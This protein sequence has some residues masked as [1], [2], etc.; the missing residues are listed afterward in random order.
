MTQKRR[1]RNF[2]ALTF[3]GL[4]IQTG[5]SH[6]ANPVQERR[7]LIGTTAADQRLTDYFRDHASRLANR[8]L[9]NIK[10][11]KT[12]ETKR[13]QYR[14]Q[15]FEMLGLSP[16]P[17]KTDLKP[18][19]TN[20]ITSD[21]FIVENITFQSRPGLYVTGNL[22]RPIKQEGRIP[23]ILYVCGHG[24]VKKNGVIYGNKVHYQHHGEWFARNGYICLTIDTLQLGEIEGI[25]HGTYREGMWWW[26]SRGYTPAG[27]EAW[28]CIRALDYLQ[29]R[30]EVD[31][32]KLGVTGRSGGGAYS[33]W[34][35]ALDE[36]IK[37]AVPVAGI[38][39]LK[40]HVIDGA[41]EGH[42]DCMFM[43]NTYQWD[44]AQVAALVAPRP[45][46]ISNTDKDSIFP[47]DGV[48]DVYNS[49]MKIYELYG[50][51]ENLGLQITEGPHKDTQE[52]R[53]HSFRWFNH[54][55][56]G[57]DSLI[58]MAATKFHTP[59]ELKVFKTLPEDQKNAK[60]QETFVKQGKAKV[61][62]DSA[63]WHQMREQWKGQLLKKSFRA[64]PKKKDSSTQTKVET[65]IK[66]GLTLKT[67]SFDSQKHVPLKLFVVI[68]ENTK[69]PRQVELAVLNQTEWDT[70]LK[71]L[72]PVFSGR[73]SATPLSPR[74]EK[75]FQKLRKNVLDNQSAVAYFTPR[76][77]GLDVWNSEE[78]KQIQIR[79]RFYLLGQSLEGMQIWD[80]RR[81]IQ[82]LQAQPEFAKADL[83][84]V[85]TGQAAAL[86]LYAS[87]FEKG[88]SELD[89]TGMPASH[90]HGPALL[91][92]LRFMDLPQA[93]AMAA[94]RSR[95]KLNDVK[96]EDWKYSA[97]VGQKMGWG[98]KQ[99]Q[100]SK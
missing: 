75:L 7:K 21:G 61:P 76:G 5:G 14:K 87:L 46:L 33:W 4:L 48:V 92:V 34:I 63:Q 30:P 97:E 58:E 12:W 39:N 41:V 88:I 54:F 15:L 51:P 25:H 42:C 47:L 69:M 22:Y 49:T 59:E 81:A 44:Y 67:I 64:W 60:I 86:C 45:L 78:R 65:S 85:G 98:E 23:A 32:E 57:D 6:A 79:R 40:N 38:T 68:P 43:V 9:K 10:D 28:N 99:L 72:T 50:V 20:S 3:I 96:L 52:L 27:V 1:H 70:Y 35:A 13:V 36:R 84:L 18:V 100:I 24:G 62:E 82:E 90:Q 11:L 55:L 93:L 37:A 31:G 91:N 53:I 16:L 94:S 26:L 29:S 19:I 8:S 77:I 89:L 56:K 66:D 73:D 83:R 80:V 71:E 95:V 74:G 2:L 17:P